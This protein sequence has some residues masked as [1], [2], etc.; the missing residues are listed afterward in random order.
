VEVRSVLAGIVDVGGWW[1][2]E[3]NPEVDVVAGIGSRVLAVGSI[4]WRARATELLAAWQ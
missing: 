4:T 2:R 1:N 3:H